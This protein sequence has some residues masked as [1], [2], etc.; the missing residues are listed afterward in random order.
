MY[1]DDFIGN[2]PFG[3]VSDFWIRHPFITVS[4]FVAAIP[5]NNAAM[6]GAT[7]FPMNLNVSVQL[8]PPDPNDCCASCCFVSSA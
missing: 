3:E 2:Q 5:A 1:H 6:A 7:Y 8:T 4:Y